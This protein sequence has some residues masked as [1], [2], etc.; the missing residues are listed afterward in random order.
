LASS[1]TAWILGGLVVLLAAVVIPLSILAR[2]DSLAEVGPNL[3]AAVSFAAVGLVVARHRPG[4]RIGWLMIAVAIGVSLYTDSG[5][6]D[7]I[8]YRLGRQLPLG[9]AVL[10]LYHAT[11]PMLGLLPLVILVFPDG[12]LPS[13]RWR[14][15]L[16]GYLAVGLA[17]MA[18]LTVAAAYAITRHR[19]QV[20]ASG[21]LTL[22]SRVLAYEAAGALAAAVVFAALWLLS[23]G[24]QMVSWRRS[25]GER[26]QQLKWLMAGGAS[27]FVSFAIAVAL[28]LT[29]GIWRALGGVLLAGIAALPVGIGVGILKYRLYDIDRIISRTLAYTIVTGLLI[30][31]YAGLVLLA[32]QVRW[33]HGQVAVAAATLVA[34]ALFNPLRRRVQRAVDRRFNRAR[35]DADQT[36]SAFAARLKDAVELDTVR[37][38][39]TRAVSRA[40]EPAHVSVWI[41][42]PD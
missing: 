42:R 20:D 10:L 3:V 12:R 37:D 27:A 26:R 17:D 7:V 22:A 24:Y 38:D 11:E 19:I 15:V 9:P 32:T 34:A 1:T 21:Q 29:H 2:R 4:N 40:L 35:Y 16:C 39:L 31:L 18:V 30:G 36:I 28:G 6:Y 25:A 23:V 8:N 33:I 13:P 5:L 14:W 41:S